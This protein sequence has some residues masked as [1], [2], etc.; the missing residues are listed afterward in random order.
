MSERAIEERQSSWSLDIVWVV[1][2]S[3]L[4]FLLMLLWMHIPT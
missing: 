2:Y 1:V 4:V 3:I